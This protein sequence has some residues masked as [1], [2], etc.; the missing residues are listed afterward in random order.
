MVAKKLVLPVG[1]N[2]GWMA[3]SGVRRMW[4]PFLSC[5][6]HPPPVFASVTKWQQVICIW[7]CLCICHCVCLCLWICLCLCKMWNPSFPAHSIHHQS[8][9]ASASV[10]KWSPLS[11]YLSLSLSLSLSLQD[12]ASITKWQQVISTVNCPLDLQVR[13]STSE[14]FFS[15]WTCVCN[16]CLSVCNACLSVCNGALQWQLL[17]HSNFPLDHVLAL[18][19]QELPCSTFRSYR[20]NMCAS[21]YNGMPFHPL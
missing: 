5:T 4:N 21:L 13:V 9:L 2:I 11:F 16:D 14:T 15:I 3:T 17:H 8:L 18:S 7:N 12:S 10:T 19:V 20:S 1:A 6:Q